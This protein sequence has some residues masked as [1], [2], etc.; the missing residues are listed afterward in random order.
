MSEEKVEKKK[1]EIKKWKLI[2]NSVVFDGPEVKS[3]LIV[4]EAS[5]YYKMQARA[6][7][8]EYDAKKL[9][10]ILS[11]RDLELD[12]MMD[13]KQVAPIS[14][15]EEVKIRLEICRKKLKKL[16]AYSGEW[17]RIRNL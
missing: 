15:F 14:L 9:A 4:V 1:E 13:E 7:N 6:L 17:P 11:K 8:A 16:G 10:E 12:Q 2:N 5:E 3:D